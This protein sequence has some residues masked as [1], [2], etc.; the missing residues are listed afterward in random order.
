MFKFKLSKK[1]MKLIEKISTTNTANSQTLFGNCKLTTS[2][3]K[4]LEK[5]S[6]AHIDSLMYKLKTIDIE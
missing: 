2:S 1:I 5:V 4:H 6:H 3:G